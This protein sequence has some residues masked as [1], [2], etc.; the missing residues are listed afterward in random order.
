MGTTQSPRPQPSSFTVGISPFEAGLNCDSAGLLN[1]GFQS[2]KKDE[3]FRTAGAYYQ[4]RGN[5]PLSLGPLIAMNTPFRTLRGFTSITLLLTGFAG[6][7]LAR[8]ETEEVV[9][10]EFKASSGGFLKIDIDFGAVEVIG[11]GGDKISLHAVRKVTRSKKA[12]EEAYLKQHPI[13]FDSNAEGLTVRTKREKVHFSGWGFSQRNEARYT[14]RIP[15]R[16]RL[17][18]RTAG[19]G[20]TVREVA[21]DAK[22]QTSGGGLQFSGLHG[23]IDGSTAGGPIQVRKCEGALHVKTSGGGID[24]ADGKGELDGQTSGGGVKVVNFEGPVHVATS[25][26]G[27]TAENIRGPLVAQ[28]SGGPINASLVGPVTD[29]VRLETSGG[30]VRVTLPSSDAFDLDAST[31]GGGVTSDFPILIAGKIDHHHLLG[32][33]NGGGKVVFVRSSGGSI[34]VAKL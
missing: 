23:A 30:G 26:G 5:S 27:I 17:D 33:V 22:V 3:T 31:S 21:G 34:H 8:A 10:K 25:G 29:D 13:D 14:L 20:V 7:P 11:D 4:K 12:D 15:A 9:D 19:G 18:L 6:V 1:P 28:T 32:P 16:Y 24:V 2:A